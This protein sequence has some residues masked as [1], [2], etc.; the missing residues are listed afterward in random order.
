MRDCS[1]PGSRLLIS[2]CQ[3]IISA[4]CVGEGN[5]HLG[6]WCFVLSTLL[7]A[8]MWLHTHLQLDYKLACQWY[9]IISQM[10]LTVKYIAHVVLCLVAHAVNLGRTI[11]SI[12]F[13]FFFFSSRN[14]NLPN[15]FLPCFPSSC[16]FAEIWRI[17]KQKRHFLRVPQLNQE[18]NFKRQGPHRAYYF[19]IFSDTKFLEGEKLEGN[20]QPTDMSYTSNQD[21]QL[22]S[23][24]SWIFCW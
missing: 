6:L 24:P 3:C 4:E 23:W 2:L 18:L 5:G 14:L 16:I 22:L 21:Q 15:Q 7:K 17:L 13:S 11:C 1:L 20:L 8:Y 12:Y 10:L 19:L 9:K